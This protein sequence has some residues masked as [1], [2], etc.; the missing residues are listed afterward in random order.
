MAAREARSRVPKRVTGEPGAHARHR[1]HYDR[2]DVYVSVCTV[3]VKG[4]ATLH[5]L[6]RKTVYNAIHEVE[7][8]EDL[9]AQAAERRAKLVEELDR[10][11]TTL[12][13]AAVE[14]MLSRI[15]EGRCTSKLLVELALGGSSGGS[16]SS[17]SPGAPRTT[18]EVPAVLASP[19]VEGGEVQGREAEPD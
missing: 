9:R 15:I 2:V 4:A 19:R 10:R 3:G 5:G 14:A 17:N 12:R 11:L 1:T 6:A 13:V 16:G 7:A 18:Y 8:S